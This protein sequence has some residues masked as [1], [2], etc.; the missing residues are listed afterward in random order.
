LAQQRAVLKSGVQ[1]EGMWAKGAEEIIWHY[2][3]ED[4]FQPAFTSMSA[5]WK[6]PLE[7]HSVCVSNKE[8]D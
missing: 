8:I 4:V 2:M 6:T 3:P 7:I 5:Y 1:G